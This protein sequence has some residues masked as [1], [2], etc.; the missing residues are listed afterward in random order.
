MV[1]LVWQLESA[2]AS[3]L[4]PP[5]LLL[6]HFLFI[7]KKVNPL[8]SKCYIG[9]ER[10]KKTSLIRNCIP[11]APYVY[12]YVSEHCLFSS[13]SCQNIFQLVFASFT[14]SAFQPL[15]NSL[16]TSSQLSSS[17][18]MLWTWIVFSFTRNKG[19]TPI[20]DKKGRR[21]KKRSQL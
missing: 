7:S 5:Q 9:I 14:K 6:K 3:G 4:L 16:S 17:T 2:C 13:S 12:M 21:K 20:T 1:S 15:A 10:I 8:I 18:K 11:I 19:Y